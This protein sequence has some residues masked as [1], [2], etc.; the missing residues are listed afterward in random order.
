MYFFRIK[1][2]F[3]MIFPSKFRAGIAAWRHK[4]MRKPKM[5]T[6]SAVDGCG[7]IAGLDGGGVEHGHKR[8]VKR[9]PEPAKPKGTARF[10]TS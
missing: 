9:G 5:R 10:F 4:S 6:V 3:V 1:V 2:S 8:P 7:E